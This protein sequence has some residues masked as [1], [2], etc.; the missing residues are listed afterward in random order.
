MNP[1]TLQLPV[2]GVLPAVVPHLL[3]GSRTNA[4]RMTR[5]RRA[6][7]R[8]DRAADARR[9][10]LILLLAG[11][12]RWDEFSARINSGRGFVASLSK[13][14][15]EP[16]IIGLCT[17]TRHIGKVAT[18]LTPA[19]AGRSIS[20]CRMDQQGRGNDARCYQHLPPRSH[21][22]QSARHL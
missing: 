21:E 14:F 18:V 16:R 2:N 15:T 20:R 7:S 8:A 11:R 3:M 13:R 5:T 19:V 1:V 9:A 10:R 17:R 4:E 6:P 22:S 12:H